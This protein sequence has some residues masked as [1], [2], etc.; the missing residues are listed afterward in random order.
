MSDVT[1]ISG[2]Q[3]KAGA[4]TNI[5]ISAS[6]S[7]DYTKINFTGAP[8]SIIGAEHAL[9]FTSPLIRTVDTITLG[10]VPVSLGGT[11][12]A[13]LV[14]KRIFYGGNSGTYAQS[15]NLN[16]DHA[17]NRLGIN[18]AT[19]A[20]A[21]DVAGSVRCDGQ[22]IGVLNGVSYFTSGF[23]NTNN[24]EVDLSNFTVPV[25]GQVLVA[26]SDV[27][28][29]WADAASLLPDQAAHNGEFLTTD[30]S[31]TSWAAL[32]DQ[33][34]AQS[35]HNGEFLTTDG[36]VASWGAI[37][38]MPDPSGADEGALLT[39]VSGSGS[40][41]NSSAVIEQTPFTIV[42]SP[43]GANPLTDTFSK[44]IITSEG[45]VGSIDYYLPTAS[46]GLNFNFVVSE[47]FNVNVIAASGDKIRIDST[48]TLVTTP[49]VAA[50]GLITCVAKA[51]LVDGE[52]FTLDDGTAPVVFE[53]DGVSGPA[54]GVTGGNVAVDVSAVSTDIEIAGVVASVINGSALGMVATDNLNGT[55]GLV[56]DAVGTLGNTTSSETV[57]D[58]GF[59]V[60][61]MTSGADAITGLISSATK[62]S[63][64]NLV[65]MNATEWY[66]MAVV[67]TWTI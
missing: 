23:K 63:V 19:P 20:Y 5:N 9:T 30:G 2:N 51:N 15:A 44:Q 59:I 3:I 29:D 6:A 39:N 45:A 12:I 1:Q 57:L 67:G 31:I 66:A 47:N 10:V 16:W 35:T 18:T 52:T 38:Q 64:I 21:I 60:T 24:D 13:S 32:P 28:A 50:T 8:P 43:G 49:A 61:D 11:G 65:A 25:A 41:R 37:I 14:D 34:P 58:A 54:D 7:I 26:T 46:V 17:N 4:I 36:S 55:V 22:F 42:P 62:G 56:S 53:F 33:L 27:A 40:W 48:E